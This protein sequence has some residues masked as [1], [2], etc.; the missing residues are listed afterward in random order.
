MN[1]IIQNLIISS[2]KRNERSNMAVAETREQENDIADLSET[3]TNKLTTLFK[4]GGMKV[5]D[6]VTEPEQSAFANLMERH[7]SQEQMEFNDYRAF[8]SSIAELLAR[9][10]NTAQAIN[11][12]DGFLI[13]Y[14]YSQ[15]VGEEGN[16]ENIYF[17]CVVFLHRIDGTDINDEDLTF[18]S[19]ERIN[20][21]S[22]N[23][24]AKVCLNDWIDNEER[25]ISFK[26]G[27]GTGDVRR[28]FQTFLGCDEPVN[29]KIDTQSLKDA[30]TETCN[31]LERNSE[32]IHNLCDSAKNYCLERLNTLGEDKVNLEALSR[33]LF[34]EEEDSEIFLHVAHEEYRLSDSIGI[35]KTVL[36]TFSRIQ[37]QTE[38]YKIS[39]NASQL[40]QTI[41]FDREN[42]SLKFN[43]LPQSIID[44]VQKFQPNTTN[45][46]N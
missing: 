44:D 1:G 22:L 19:I 30:I 15:D 7:L 41:E 21:D 34:P 23:L 27:K 3:V 24:G 26:L 45:N 46:N 33:H 9:K 31:R 8:S 5:G 16:V 6:F 37:V 36:R 17:L 13:T 39:F 14:F 25:P 4:G 20:L 29:C 42:R 40:N 43:N 18:E 28:Y 38:H 10:L 11:A 35:D 32:Q 12:K 2:I